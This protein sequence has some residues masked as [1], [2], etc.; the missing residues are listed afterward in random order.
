VAG[1]IDSIPDGIV[2][3]L[4][5]RLDSANSAETLAVITAAWGPETKRVVF[6]CSAVSFVSSAGLGVFVQAARQAK[7]RGGSAH[8]HGASPT[9]L[10]L[11][12]IAGLGAVI[13][14]YVPA[15][16]PAEG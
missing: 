10:Q 16:V 4:S 9:I 15:S 3:S 13:T 12:R 7:V 2:V 14:P 11:L 8:H 5:G 6:D 1:S